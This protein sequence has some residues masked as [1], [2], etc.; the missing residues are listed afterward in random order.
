MKLIRKH[1]E[2][3]LL[4][5][6]DDFDWVRDVD[7][8]NHIE[9][10]YFKNMKEYGLSSDKYEMVL[11]KIY[12]QPV[13][14]KGDYIYDAQG[15]QIYYEGGSGY[16]QKKE[17]NDQGD[18]IY[19]EDSDGYIE[20]N[21]NINE[22]DDF[23]W[24]RDVM[25]SDLPKPGTAWVMEIDPSD[26]EQVQ[27]DLFDAGFTWSSDD[28]KIKKRNNVYALVSYSN[29]D[30]RYKQF[31]MVVGDSYIP[32][33]MDHI[34]NHA[35]PNELFVYE[36]KGGVSKLKNTN[37]NESED[38]DWIK[39]VDISDYLEKP[40]FKDMK[41]NYGLSPDEYESI[42]SIVFKQPVSI[43]G[44]HVYNDQGNEIYYED[45]DGFWWKKE[46][47][48]NGNNIYYKNS[49]G[50]WYKKEYDTNG[51]NIY[52]E[53]SD[54]FWWKKE[55]D[56][57]GNEI[58]YENS[59]GYIID[60]RHLNESDDFDWIKGVDISDYL[61]KPYFINMKEYGLKPNE[62]ESILSKVFNQPVTIKDGH[63]YNDEGNRIYY[64]GSYGLWYKKE[65]DGQ[66]NE[67]Y[68][69]DCNGNWFKREYDDQGNL[70]YTEDS[71]G[72]IIDNR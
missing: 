46:Y 54:G 64:E 1:N 18:L 16:W 26:F 52:R 37:L 70:I 53:S 69:E 17:Y 2:L 34:V 7:I 44:E 51:N 19:R 60:N 40:Y 22:S 4:K 36:Y 61:E 71:S 55:Y 63:V 59:T 65:Y 5:E 15:N 72:E 33:N 35:Q 41:D 20:D 38:F 57:Q 68:Y 21:R 31:K 9:M 13:T 8:V 24:I 62:Y 10:P 39:G 66:G 50:G 27:Q 3:N 32:D 28:V 25:P 47:D 58:Y 29:Y 12:N 48:T 23:D 42:L 14:I 43:K 45:S 67:I 6:S 11:S 30:V 56:E 49:T